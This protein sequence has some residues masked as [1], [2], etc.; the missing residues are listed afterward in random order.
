MRKIE[1]N[2]GNENIAA[3]K[4][5]IG[6]RK[7]PTGKVYGHVWFP[8]R[9]TNFRTKLLPEVE[10]DTLKVF[11]TATAKHVKTNNFNFTNEHGET[12]WHKFDPTAPSI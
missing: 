12:Q 6:I 5:E 1:T 3:Q 2:Y 9:N 7:T 10:L 8:T 11:V 4:L